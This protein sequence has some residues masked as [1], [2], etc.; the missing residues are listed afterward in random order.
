MSKVAVT[1]GAGFLGSHIVKRL[2]DDERDFSIVDDFSSGSLRN[3]ADLGVL[4]KCV[5]GDLRDYPFARRSLRG[6]DTVFHFAAEVGSVSYLHGSNARELAAMQANLIIDANVL[7]ACL[8]NGVRTVIY[9]S[10]VSVYPFD[11]QLGSHTQFREEDSERKVNPEGGYG[12]AKYVAEKQLS[13]MPEVSCGV[14]RIFHAY[15]K[16]IYLKPDRSQVIASL[17]RK[18]VRYPAEDFVVWGDGSQRRC[19]VYIEDALDALMKLEKRVLERGSLTVNVGSTEETTVRE[20]AERVIQLSKK[21]IPLKFDES[22]LTGALN[23][24]P[25]LD[26]AKSV[27]GWA[28]TTSFSK[29]LKETFDWAEHRL[30]LRG[31]G[32]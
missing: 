7:K 12:W 14:A 28:P 15:G 3:L 5:T 16:N 30:R 26:R 18:A 31:G 29:G 24:M 23:R 13:L 25:N 21:D 1:G 22:K 2:S 6:A 8:E 20:L 10:S 27:L 32:S 9:A 19:F 11:E 4:R 17:I